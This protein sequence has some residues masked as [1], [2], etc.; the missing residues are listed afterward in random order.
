MTFEYYD[1]G[2]PL[3]GVIILT[4]VVIIFLI[5]GFY[6]APDEKPERQREAP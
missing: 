4:V 2:I 3:T 6:L 5:W 1:S